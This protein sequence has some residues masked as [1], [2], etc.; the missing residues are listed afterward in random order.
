[1][2]CLQAL[3][4]CT[5]IFPAMT[6]H[7]DEYDNPAEFELDEHGA[8]ELLQI[9]CGRAFLPF[10][11]ALDAD[12]ARVSE[13]KRRLEERNQMKES[14]RRHSLKELYEWKRDGV[15]ESEEIDFGKDF[16]RPSLPISYHNLQLLYEHDDA[17]EKENTVISVLVRCGI[18]TTLYVHG[19]HY[20]ID[21][22]QR[23]L[24]NQQKRPPSQS[25]EDLCKKYPYIKDCD[26]HVHNLPVDEKPPGL[27]R[28]GYV[29]ARMLACFY[30]C[31][32]ASYPNQMLAY[33][34]TSVAD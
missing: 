1:M 2:P 24:E 5:D 27:A 25:H 20:K 13:R 6:K 12:Q 8:R 22:L 3:Q 15:T 17:E 28:R 10:L 19:L 32:L 30:F 31:Y 11:T 23:Q 21:D 16:P 4:W 29:S 33:S 26:E 34:I 9:V 7:L 14:F 18:A